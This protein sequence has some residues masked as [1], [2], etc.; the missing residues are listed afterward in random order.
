MRQPAGQHAKAALSPLTGRLTG[1]CTSRV[2]GR[3]CCNLFAMSFQPWD[4]SPPD[5][6]C[7]NGHHDMFPTMPPWKQFSIMYAR[8]VL[9]SSSSHSKRLWNLLQESILTL[10]AWNF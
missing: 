9:F 7:V 4:R 3:T 5:R 2:Y 8:P 1:V 10:S 6:K